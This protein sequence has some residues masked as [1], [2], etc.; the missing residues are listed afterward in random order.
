MKDGE[1]AVC[2]FKKQKKPLTVG[3]VFELHCKWPPFVFL[4]SPARIEFPPPKG[5]DQ[6]K[7][8]QVKAPKNPYTL[9]LLDTVSLLPGKGVFKVTGY[10]PGVYHTGFK[11]VSDEG[12]VNVKPLSWRV[13][14][15][16]PQKSKGTIKP[17][18]PYGPWGEA[19]PF[20]HKS[21]SAL[22]LLA[23]LVFT[24]L[25]IRFFIR[26][27]RKT[28]E[29]KDRL[30]GKDPFREFISRLNLLAR[31]IQQEEEK[32]F[33]LTLR[34][35]FCLFLENEFCIFALNEKSEKIFYRL[36]TSWPLVYKD[37]KIAGLF[38]EMDRLS[39]E[40]TKAIDRGQLLN[41]AREVAIKIYQ[42][43]QAKEGF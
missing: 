3:D 9:T 28:K 26:K 31:K 43:R 42:H 37:S 11:I 27:K 18:P 7:G 19:L 8:S 24:V 14:S 12:V 5:K 16:I 25:K 17:F 38:K 35:T 33:V 22:S 15:V 36:K 1:S 2:Q 34:K 20:W 10:S 4:S 32:N 13:E 39:L 29:V 6:T 40:K 41:M 21:L 23:L 30:K